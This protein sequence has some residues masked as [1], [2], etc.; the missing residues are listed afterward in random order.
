MSVLNLITHSLALHS[1]S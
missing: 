1:Y